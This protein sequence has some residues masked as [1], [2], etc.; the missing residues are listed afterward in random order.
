[1][2]ISGIIGGILLIV[3]AVLLLT[4][5]GTTVVNQTFTGSCAGYVQGNDSGCGLE[6]V[7]TTGAT[8]YGLIELL[9]PIIGVMIIVGIGFGLKSKS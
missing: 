2:N 5:F 1:M 9:Y 8:M 4:S 6:N 7:S 3:I